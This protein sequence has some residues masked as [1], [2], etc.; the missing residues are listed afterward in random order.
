MNM[1]MSDK[2]EVMVAFFHFV[3]CS[4]GDDIY[5][6]KENAMLPAHGVQEV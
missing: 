4:L 2:P 5:K 3:H 1:C 6:Y